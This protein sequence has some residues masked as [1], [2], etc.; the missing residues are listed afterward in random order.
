MSKLKLYFA[1]NRRHKGRDRWHP[2]GYDT[3]F[4]QDGMENLRVGSLTVDVDGDRVARY[5]KEK[6]RHG[7]GNG[8]K[9]SGYIASRVRSTKHCSIRAYREDLK[10]DVSD[11]N[12]PDNAKWGS[13][14]MFEDLRKAMLGCSDVLVYIHGFNVSWED[15]VGSA[16][17]LQEMVNQ[18]VD[19]EP[20]QK[21]V[22]VLFTWPS[23]GK[24]LPYVSYKSDRSEATASGAAIGRGFLK[25]R[26][27]LLGLREG[28]RKG[29]G[30]IE[31]CEQEIHLLCHSMGNYVLQSALAR[32]AEFTPG[33][34]MP[35][36]FNHIFMCAPDVDDTVFE[37]GQPMERLHEIAR[38]VSIYCNHE[39]VAMTISDVTKGNPDRLGHHGAARPALLHAKVHQVDC[40]PVVVE[41]LTEHSYYLSGRPDADI[42][43]SINGL[44]FDDARRERERE[45]TLRNV[46]TL[47]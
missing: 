23:D 30:E 34:T 17:A 19:G 8:E 42:R 7:T 11:R 46:W 10:A 44:P 31:L 18:P 28:A 20:V 39:D 29:G 32:L 38:Q 13:H 22:V 6:L 25:V 35:R 37:E 26:D 24:A 41:G 27:Y 43:M 1:T 14:A 9:L 21:V 40:T 3:T 4:S 5:L 15:A 47:V 36:L 33:K 45:T 2:T 12:Q 16:L